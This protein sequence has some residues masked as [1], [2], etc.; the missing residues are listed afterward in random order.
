MGTAGSVGGFLFTRL[1][2]FV[3]AHYSYTIVFLLAGSLHLLASLILWTL[4]KE[5]QLKENPCG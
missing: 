2:G 1:V 4:M 5:T 3:L